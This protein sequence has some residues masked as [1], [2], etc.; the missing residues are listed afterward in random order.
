MDSLR[1]ILIEVTPQEYQ[2]IMSG[3][4][5]G[6]DKVKTVD[7]VFEL[8]RRCKEKGTSDRKFIQDKW[9]GQNFLNIKGELRENDTRFIFDMSMND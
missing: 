4:F 3:N 6:L 5:N 8:E 1:K 2:M 9:T 7:L